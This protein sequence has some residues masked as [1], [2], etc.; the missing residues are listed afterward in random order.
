MMFVLALVL[1]AAPAALARRVR[2]A[3]FNVE[4]GIGAPDSEKYQAQKAVLRRVDAEIVAFQELKRASSNHWVR[5]AG[6][7]GYPHHAWGETGPFAGSMDLG[8]F[9][10]HPILDIGPV[11]SPEGASEFSRL[12][13][14][15]RV[16]VPG[17]ARPLVLWNIHHKA[18]FEA[19]D[20]FRRAI[21]ARR[22]ADDV[23]RHF[24]ERPDEV[25]LV[26]LG[27]MNDD[28]A[29]PDQSRWFDSPPA[30]L[31]R[32]YVL[33]ADISFPIHYR[34]FPLAAYT[35]V[36]PRFRPVRAFRQ[37][38]NIPITH[39]YTN[40]RL[41]W[42]FAGRAFWRHP[43][44]PPTGEIYHSE[45]DAPEGGGLP[46]AGAPLP[47]ETSLQASDHYIVFADLNMEDAPP[48]EESR[49]DPVESKGRGA[50]NG[51]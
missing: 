50:A 51:N 11:V 48:S 44:G 20:D 45:W 36:G 22:I 42:I 21:E 19:R 4:N 26:I 30:S 14:R 28:P 2:I 38:S 3:T 33:G 12:P 43:D 47:P 31:P 29:R 18:M 32:A 6:E 49:D 37:N 35:S 24:R 41:D 9:S 23:L 27:D 39:F 7:L 15:V 13:L 17:A 25:E 34:P 40:L 8:F 1:V 46:K 16:H 10:R 5:L